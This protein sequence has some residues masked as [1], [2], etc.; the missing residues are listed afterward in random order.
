MASAPIDPY[1]LVDS[2]SLKESRHFG[3]TLSKGKRTHRF[4]V[5]FSEYR[6]ELPPIE[7]VLEYIANEATIYEQFGMNF[8]AYMR[9]TS[10]PMEAAWAQLQDLKSIVPNY[11]WL[12]GPAYDELVEITEERG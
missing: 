4:A 7:D 8:D 12:L 6:T 10:Q 1:G 3:V 11:K 9:F 2:D 5:V